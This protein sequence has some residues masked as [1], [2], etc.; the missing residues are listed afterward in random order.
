MMHGEITIA[1]NTATNSNG[2][3]ISLYQSDLEIKDICIIF[4]NHA[5]R[6]GGI[7]ATT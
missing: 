1:N 4:Q 2:G 3:G 7:H 6:G 5:M